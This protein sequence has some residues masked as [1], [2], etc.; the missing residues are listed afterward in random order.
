MKALASRIHAT[1]ARNAQTFETLRTLANALGISIE[2]K[3]G[4]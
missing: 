4:A 2:L 1:D 3:A